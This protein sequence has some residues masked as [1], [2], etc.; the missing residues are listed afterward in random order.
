MA[1]KCSCTQLAAAAH[2][3]SS[4]NRW[5]VALSPS[6]GEEV[7]GGGCWADRCPHPAYNTSTHTKVSIQWGCHL[8]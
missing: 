5:G 7:G 8:A 2:G 3:P 1:S 4:R 6:E